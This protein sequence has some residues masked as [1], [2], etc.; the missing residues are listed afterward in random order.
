MRNIKGS[1]AVVYSEFAKHVI[2]DHWRHQH[3]EHLYLKAL[4]QLP[5]EGFNLLLNIEICIRETLFQVHKILE[6]LPPLLHKY[7]YYLN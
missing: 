7:S 6:K 3:V 2:I 4:A 5:E 1:K